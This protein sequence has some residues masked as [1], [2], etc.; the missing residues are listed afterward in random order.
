VRSEF[1]D[2][3]LQQTIARGAEFRVV[4]H[5]DSIQEH[6]DHVSVHTSDGVLD[7]R[8]LVGADGANSVVQRLVAELGPI[9]RGFAI[10]AQ[11]PSSTPP[12]MEFDFGVVEYG[13][14]WLFPK[15]DHIN[16]GLYTNATTIRPGRNALADYARAKTGSPVLEHVV[17]HQVGLHGW[18]ATLAT[19]RSALVGDAA[20]LVDPLLGEGIH[21]AVA[22]GQAVAAAI[23]TTLQ[24]GRDLRATYARELG[25]LLRDLRISW[26]D[27]TRFYSNID[28]GYRAL[29][30]RMVSAALMKGYARGLSFS[31]IRRWFPLLPFLPMWSRVPLQ[32]AGRRSR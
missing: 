23:A 16:V 13:Y 7:A 26:K 25:P 19:A 11:I 6:S 21:N 9:E 15:R 32:P 3:C 24:I 18:D 31:S 5:I 27:A 10:E 12:P 28:R 2:Y 29:T 30:N 4:P 1:D 8:Y 22:S 14:G 17:G 20:G